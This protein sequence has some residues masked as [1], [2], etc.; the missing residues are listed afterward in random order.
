LQ[1]AEGAELTNHQRHG[2]EQKEI[3]LKVEQRKSHGKSK[4]HWR[5]AVTWQRFA[6]NDN[7]TTMGKKERIFNWIV[8]I[9]VALY[10]A[11]QYIIA[12]QP[13]N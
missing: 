10:Q 4:V 9:A 1:L 5:L 13:V 3:M 6:A 8:T 2:A 7:C 11:I 12:N